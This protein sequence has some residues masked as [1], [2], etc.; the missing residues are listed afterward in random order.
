MSSTLV[1]TNILSRDHNKEQRCK[2]VNTCS[3]DWDCG[4]AAFSCVACKTRTE[5]CKLCTQI[6][7]H[8]SVTINKSVMYSLVLSSVKQCS[9]CYCY[10][11]FKGN[12]KEISK[13]KWH[14]RREHYAQYASNTLAPKGCG[15]F[16]ARVS[17][18]ASTCF[19]RA[20]AFSFHKIF[21]VVGVS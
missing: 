8:L 15:L 9:V 3:K 12:F 7:H 20:V 19:L 21:P 18:C 5:N 13:T 10:Q 4:K 2:K 14:S 1:K 6:C 17:H 16:C 11:E